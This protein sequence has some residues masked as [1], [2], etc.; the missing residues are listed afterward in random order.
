MQTFRWTLP[1]RWKK[2]CGSTTNNPDTNARKGQG[3]ELHCA[4]SAAVRPPDDLRAPPRSAEPLLTDA[5][6]G[7]RR[8][9]A[10]GEP[11]ATTAPP[12]KDYK[13]LTAYL[14]LNTTQKTP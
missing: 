10:S 11:Q 6:R 12:T 7:V 5:G 2:P 1:P 8:R 3:R 9:S 4:L 13:V 14:L